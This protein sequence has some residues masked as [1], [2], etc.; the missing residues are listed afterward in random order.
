MGFRH[1]K[2]G[3]GR[4]CEKPHLLQKVNED[5]PAY[6]SLTTDSSVIPLALDRLPLPVAAAVRTRRPKGLRG[7]VRGW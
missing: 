1:E 3:I 5:S 6:E 4:T 2:E 7:A